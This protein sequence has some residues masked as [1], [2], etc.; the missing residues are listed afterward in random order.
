MEVSQGVG[1]WQVL[2]FFR[3]RE[4]RQKG[5]GPSARPSASPEATISEWILRSFAVFFSYDN[6]SGANCEMLRIDQHESGKGTV[7]LGEQPHVTQ[8]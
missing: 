7:S 5:S 8:L 2:I 3:T 1:W 6:I 4:G